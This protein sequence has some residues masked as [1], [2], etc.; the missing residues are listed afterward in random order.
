MDVENALLRLVQ[1]QKFE[2]E[3]VKVLEKR[4]FASC[5][6][7][8]VAFFASLCVLVAHINETNKI[9]ASVV[10]SAHI[11]ETNKILT[12]VVSFV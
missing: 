12:I 7:A 4:T 8:I 6:F 11:N 3:R 1:V 10:S 9:L 5:I 2:A